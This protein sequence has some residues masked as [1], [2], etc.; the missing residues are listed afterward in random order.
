MYN[1]CVHFTKYFSFMSLGPGGSLTGL[2]KLIRGKC[3]RLSI[4]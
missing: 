3:M 2:K 4:T 1:E